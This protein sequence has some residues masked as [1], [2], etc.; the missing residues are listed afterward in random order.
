MAIVALVGI[1]MAHCDNKPAAAMAMAL[2]AAAVAISVL[3]IASHARP[4]TGQIS[5]GPGLLQEI[6]R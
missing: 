2:F 4:F 6:V 1:A 3:L 5:V